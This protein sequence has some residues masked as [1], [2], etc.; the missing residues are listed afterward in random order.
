MIHPAPNLGRIAII[1]MIVGT[2][3]SGSVASANGP[4][5]E[6]ALE[7]GADVT[8]GDTL[9]GV[10][11]PDS[12]IVSGRP[13][14]RIDDNESMV[15]TVA[16][17]VAVG[18]ANYLPEPIDVSIVDGVAS[19]AQPLPAVVGRGDRVEIE[20]IG[21][22]FIDR[23]FDDSTCSLVDGR[24]LQPIEAHGVLAFSA[25]AAFGSLAEAVH[26][27]ADADHLRT[28]DLV[29]I[30]RELEL[31]CYGGIE[32]RTP[33]MIDAWVTS[34]KNRIRI[35]A[36][37]ASYG[38]ELNWRHPGRWSEDAYRIEVWGGDCLRTTVG[39]LTI[40]GLQFLCTADAA[41][42]VT[43]IHLDAITGEVEISEVL[44]HLAGTGASAERVAVKAT[45]WG[46]A[47]LVVRNTMMW[48]LGASE[49]HA[50]ILVG[51]SGVTLH[52]FNNTIVGGG[53]GIRNLG[54]TATATNNLV[55]ASG[56]ASFDGDFEPAST[57]NLGADASTPGPSPNAVGPVTMVNP[58]PGLD[59][60]FHL[61]CGVMAQKVAIDHPFEIG[62]GEGPRALFDGD[63]DS[64]LRS[65]SI[66]PAKVVL[67]FAE[68]RAVTGTSAIFSHHW[69]YTWMVAAAD[70]V[71]DLAPGSPSYRVLVPERTVENEA[72]S[73]DGV[74]FDQPEIF[75]VIELTVW[76]N[77]GDDY[78]HVNEWALDSL[79]PACGQGA[80]LSK[81]PKHPFSSDIDSNARTGPWDIG[82]DQHEGVTVVAPR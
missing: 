8:G 12:V 40:E 39:N 38:H 22:V 78:V 31:V 4:V 30:N 71:E 28:S 23:C 61:Q 18:A 44:I 81:N 29:A 16:Y 26:G 21:T 48:G 74:T 50:G 47:E 7:T 13:G 25:T 63:P 56:L 36:A 77:G 65:A 34:A 76:R 51:D 43:A 14:R 67:E 80:D 10:E 60:D 68:E 33:V 5:A 46:A 66:N 52:A 42:P 49:L 82:A 32:D 59:A 54:G 41:T 72:I 57:R 73:W 6:E 37:D 2:A 3:A 9:R 15:V 69:S 17:S 62:S 20:G 53:W 35:V 11:R 24:G 55:A 79:N 27:A 58:V 1:L 45:S 19:F 75:N 64:L 70:S